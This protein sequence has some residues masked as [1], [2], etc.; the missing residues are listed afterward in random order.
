[1]KV[2][3]N[4]C[5][6]GFGL[7]IAGIKRYAKLKG[8]TIYPYR[9]AIGM[10]HMARIEDDLFV[11]WATVPVPD[12]GEAP[13]GTYW[14]EY[15]IKRDDP[16]LIATIEQLGKKANGRCAELCVVEIPDGVDYTIEEYDGREHIAEA[17]RTWP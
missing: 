8:I 4:H 7:S 3:I 9:D 10:R 6:G 1:M 15:N 16:A 17:H 12:G 2:A 5:F 11:H 13:D 14:S